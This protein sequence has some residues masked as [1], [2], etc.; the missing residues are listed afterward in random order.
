MSGNR[1]EFIVSLV[2]RV[3][4]PL[5]K[6]TNLMGNMQR[7]AATGPLAKAHKFTVQLVDKVTSPLRSL[8]AQN[9]GAIKRFQSG[10]GKLKSGAM[11]LAAP[12]QDFM[13][14]V[15]D[16]SREYQTITEKFNQYGMGGAALAEAEKFASA[17]NI[18]GASRVDMLRYM[19]EAQGVFRESG[20]KTLDE[21]LAAAK[22]AA[23]MLAKVNVASKGLDEH[24][25]GLMQDQQM[26]MLRFTEQM[27]GLKSPERFNELMSG[28]FKAIQSSGGNVNWDQL[29]QFVS[30]AGSSAYQLSDQALFAKLEP[31]IGEMK[32]GAAG[33]ALMTSF[34]R[35]NGIVKNKAMAHKMIDYGIWN[36]DAVVFDKLGGVKKFVPG[37]RVLDQDTSSL[38]STDPVA[39]YEKVMLPKYK[40]RGLSESDIMTENSLIFGR[41]GG[42]MFNLIHKQQEPIH[43]S[44]EAFDK[45]RGIDGSYEA[46]QK[47]YAGQQ[48]SL[49]AKWKDFQLALGQDG[50]LLD[51]ATQGLRM[52]GD[53]VSWLTN[54]AHEHPALAR[55]AMVAGGVVAG[56]AGFS[57]VAGVV[58]MAV[59]A[60]EMLGAVVGVILSPIG[61]LVAG[62]VSGNGIRKGSC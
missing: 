36:E 57:M 51:M 18:A 11:E 50:G 35:M 30:K 47:N 55:F 15:L 7:A 28:G 5:N 17:A 61:L 38:L 56:L 29:R 25:Q 54:A 24:M 53:A 9:S 37:K 62:V 12:V 23:P 10:F 40:G 3:T 13:H 21:Q 41:Q 34:Q 39:F 6:I 14:G 26:D 8:I 49:D 4:G 58:S 31:I 20:A 32:G 59:G 16:T 19:T 2:D 46:I 27:G 52:L 43:R 42:K 45:A 33:D 44:V 1:L 60:L 48:M 22:M